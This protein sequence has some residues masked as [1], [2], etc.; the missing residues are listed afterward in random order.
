[1][2]FTNFHRED[3]VLKKLEAKSEFTK[4]VRSTLTQS[5]DYAVKLSNETL[6][7]ENFGFGERSILLKL[8]NYE[9]S[10]DKTQTLH[11]YLISDSFIE[12]NCEL[13][14]RSLRVEPDVGFN[15]RTLIGAQMSIEETNWQKNCKCL[16]I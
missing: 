9:P 7:E 10:N 3:V 11:S 1:M 12:I 2:V 5:Q 15:A 6:V 16:I 4:E 13:L 8:K 14:V